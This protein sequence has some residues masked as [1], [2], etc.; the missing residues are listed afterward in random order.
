MISER[1]SDNIPPEMKILNIVIP[2]LMQF[3]SFE[4]CKPHNAALHL[5]K[6]DIINDV[7]LLPT[8]NGRIYCCKFLRYPIRSSVT[9]V[10]ALE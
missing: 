4:R 1:I 9:K 3:C 10:S 8:V 6:S 7:K 2:I 5:M